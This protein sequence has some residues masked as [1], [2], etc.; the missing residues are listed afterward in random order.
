MENNENKNPE[1]F[2]TQRADTEEVVI[3]EEETTQV[4]DAP[5]AP[6]QPAAN[7][8]PNPAQAWAAPAAQTAKPA[9][10]KP[11][12]RKLGIASFV[13]AVSAAVLAFIALIVASVA[14]HDGSDRHERGGRGGRADTQIDVT[15]RGSSRSGRESFMLEEDGDQ[16][17]GFS[18]RGGRGLD[19][20]E[21]DVQQSGERGPRV[22]MRVG[23][24]G[25]VTITEEDGTN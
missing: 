1:E 14:L 20:V 16:V 17:V 4:F 22:S 13:I 9:E 2:N 10:V 8:S 6:P 21:M 5:G 24:D 11:A 3:A 19:I 15:E 7:Q 12:S 25:Q 18:G 23:E